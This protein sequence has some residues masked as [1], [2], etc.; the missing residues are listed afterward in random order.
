MPRRT[1]DPTAALKHV[2]VSGVNLR[3]LSPK[4]VRPNPKMH[5]SSLFP[6]KPNRI[7][8]HYRSNLYWKKSISIR[9]PHLFASSNT[10]AG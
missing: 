8:K 2:V 3:T 1:V 7:P 9:S 5:F 10:S 6:M 4:L